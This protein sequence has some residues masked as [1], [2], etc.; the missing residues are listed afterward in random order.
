MG[1]SVALMVSLLVFPT[2]A[3]KLAKE[4]AADMLDLIARIL[5][6]LFLGF[7]QK[8]DEDAIVALQ[9]SVGV[10]FSKLDLIRAEAKHEQ[11]TF[12]ASEPG[13]DR[14]RHSLLRLRHDLVMIGRAAT[15]PLPETLQ[16][17]VGPLLARVTD[18][19][20]EHLRKCGTALRN[21][22]HPSRSR[23]IGR[24]IRRI[25]GAKSRCFAARA[26]C[27]NSPSRRWSM[28]SR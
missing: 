18:A 5:P 24:G 1:G 3:R 15:T 22:R 19:A 20:V 8:S 14:L 17:R 7:A 2:R 28:F 25:R 11:M 9:R 10:A 4:G 21:R 27:E 26:C 23:E 16:G 12:L 13:F 6:D